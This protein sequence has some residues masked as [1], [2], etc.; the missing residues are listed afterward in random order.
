VLRGRG[1]ST[2][3]GLV[4]VVSAFLVGDALVRGDWE[5]VLRTTPPVGLVLWAIW[6]LLLRPSIGFDANGLVVVN[7][8]RIVRVP[9]EDVEYIGMRYQIVVETRSG[10]TIRCWGGPTLPRPQ[11]ARRGRAAVMPR[12]REVDVLNDARD[13]YGAAP[14]GTPGGGTATRAWDTVALVIG[15]VCAV[16]TVLAVTLP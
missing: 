11:P 14:H 7:V 4:A 3:F 2:A 16:A 12:A 5:V 10:P 13:R 6:V 15:A 1:G 8:L 9:W